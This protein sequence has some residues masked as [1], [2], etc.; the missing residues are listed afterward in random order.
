[1]KYD[2]LFRMA[3]A[4]AINRDM[5]NANMVPNATFSFRIHHF[6]LWRRASFLILLCSAQTKHIAINCGNSHM[7]GATTPYSMPPH[8]FAILQSDAGT[9]C[10]ADREKEQKNWMLKINHRPM[11]ATRFLNCFLLS[12]FV[13]ITRIRDDAECVCADCGSDILTR[14]IVQLMIFKYTFSSVSFSLPPPPPSM[15]YVRTAIIWCIYFY[16]RHVVVAATW[17]DRFM[18]NFLRNNPLCVFGWVSVAISSPIAFSFVLFSVFSFVFLFRSVFFFMSIS[19]GSQR[20]W[21]MRGA[22]LSTTKKMTNSHSRYRAVARV[23]QQTVWAFFVRGNWMGDIQNQS[24][25][26]RHA[27]GL[28]TW[29]RLWIAVATTCLECVLKFVFDQYFARSLREIIIIMKKKW[30]SVSTD[31]RSVRQ[32]WTK[33]QI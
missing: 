33:P 23:C 1:M 29:L 14:H 9:L 6:I 32:V 25:I 22:A 30:K 12:A 2:R 8:V 7:F 16:P 28:V 13:F 26:K 5:C 24:P 21:F 31:A 27:I 19:H 4:A 10:L 11:C 17:L 15:N 3:A 20:L 18:F